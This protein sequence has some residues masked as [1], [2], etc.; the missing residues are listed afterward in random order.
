MPYTWRRW[1]QATSSMPTVP[2]EASNAACIELTIHAIGLDD[3][4]SL[5]TTS[6][7]GDE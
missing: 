2:R 6:A 5:D 4:G 7:Q 1:L 3:A